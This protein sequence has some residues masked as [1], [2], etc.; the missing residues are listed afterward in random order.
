MHVSKILCTPPEVGN[1]GQNETF[2]K[3]EKF[4]IPSVNIQSS[5]TVNITLHERQDSNKKTRQ[6]RH[7]TQ[8]K[9]SPKFRGSLPDE[10]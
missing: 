7:Q 2:G 5:L 8:K 3:R 9:D 6:K 1:F 4:A 10:K